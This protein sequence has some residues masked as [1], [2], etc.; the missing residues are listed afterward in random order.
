MKDF[1]TKKIEKIKKERASKKKIE[2][3]LKKTEPDLEA[4]FNNIYD[5]SYLDQ[6]NK[7]I[8]FLNEDIKDKDVPRAQLLRL[9]KTKGGFSVACGTVASDEYYKYVQIYLAT[10][11]TIIV[12]PIDISGTDINVIPGKSPVK[13]GL[14][15]PV[16]ALRASCPLIEM[17]PSATCQV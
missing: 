10:E 7:L 11:I 13:C 5:K 4:L 1:V 6:V 14:A 9:I 12:K 8:D 2:E 17:K 15:L 3:E 16:H